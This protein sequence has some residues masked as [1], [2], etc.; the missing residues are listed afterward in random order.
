MRNKWENGELLK[1]ELGSR[2]TLV[3]IPG[4]GH[5][6]LTNRTDIALT[7]WAQ[8]SFDFQWINSGV[9]SID[10]AIVLGTRLLTRF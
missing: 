7:P 3:Q 8:L 9:K 6:V 10:N 2:A 4:A 1:L 5:L